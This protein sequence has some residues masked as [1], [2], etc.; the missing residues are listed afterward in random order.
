MTRSLSASSSRPN[1]S[2]CSG[3]IV[4][5]LPATVFEM[6]FCGAKVVTVMTCPLWSF[7]IS[8]REVDVTDGDGH[9]DLHVF[10]V[11]ARHHAGGQVF[12]HAACL[13]A[14]AAVADAHAASAFGGQAGGLGLRE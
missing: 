14:G 12:H 5:V 11:T 6:D 9:A 3:V 7:S 2:A 10:L 13:A 4:M 8:Q 1:A